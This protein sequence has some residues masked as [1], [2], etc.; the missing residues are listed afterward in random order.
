LKGGLQV[1]RQIEVVRKVKSFFLLNELDH[2]YKV[3]VFFRN[4]SF[5]VVAEGDEHQLL[6]FENISLQNLPHVRSFLNQDEVAKGSQLDE[7]KNAKAF[8]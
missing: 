6:N 4:H 5:R 7:S 8:L 3:L 2:V 1:F